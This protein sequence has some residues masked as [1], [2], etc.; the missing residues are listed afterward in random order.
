M[1]K[2]AGDETLADMFAAFGRSL[3]I[4][5]VDVDAVV[6]HHRKNLD[7]LQKAV[8]ASASGGA[9]VVRKQTEALQAQV[10]EIG[11]MARS[12]A[13]GAQPHEIWAKH[14][15]ALQ[16]SFERAVKDTGEIAEIVQKSGSESVAALRTRIQ[17]SMEEI[18]KVVEKGSR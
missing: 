2:K 5:P 8:A 3:R 14:A 18:R 4:P 1:T 6:E 13:P 11:A 9:A 17:S 16:R 10:E 12:L 15:D 7:A